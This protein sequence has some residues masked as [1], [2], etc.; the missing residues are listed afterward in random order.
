MTDNQV[1]HLLRFNITCKCERDIL[2]YLNV[3]NFKEKL[4][5]LC[6]IC[7]AELLKFDIIDDTRYVF[8]R[9]NIHD[10]SYINEFIFIA[11]NDFL[12]NMIRIGIIHNFDMK[13]FD[14]ISS[15]PEIPGVYT[16]K[17]IIPSESPTDSI[18][19]IYNIFDM[20]KID[21]NNLFFKIKSDQAIS[22]IRKK[23]N[24]DTIN[25][26]LINEKYTIKY[27]KSPL[28]RKGCN[29]IESKKDRNVEIINGLRNALISQNKINDRIEAINKAQDK[30]DDIDLKL[31][32]STLTMNNNMLFYSA[33]RSIMHEILKKLISYEEKNIKT[34]KDYLK[35]KEEIES[36]ESD[37]LKQDKIIKKASKVHEHAAKEKLL[38]EAFKAYKHNPILIIT[39]INHYAKNNNFEKASNFVEIGK[40][41]FPNLAEFNELEK[42][43]NTNLIRSRYIE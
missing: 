1:H 23:L 28:P 14:D 33:Y 15:N 11:S 38:I 27:N 3:H 4:I 9:N 19:K 41:R 34:L 5:L 22:M 10:I 30:I 17:A 13:M 18:K 36:A 26:K 40:H 2:A 42:E 8:S 25:E 39:I 21:D 20:F 32:Y 37:I 43:I 6:P 7:G 12:P 35:K 24:Y 16:I 31:L 29:E